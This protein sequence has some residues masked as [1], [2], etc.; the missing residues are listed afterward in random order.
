MPST[1]L[2]GVD[3]SPI[4]TGQQSDVPRDAFLYFNDVYRQCARVGEWKL[5]VTR[6]NTPAYSPDPP[7]G[8]VNLP[9]P[10]PELYNVVSDPQESYDRSERSPDIVADIKAR[11]ARLLPTFPN[12][13]I[14]AWNDTMRHQVENTPADSLPAE[15]QP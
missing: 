8:R 6:Y 12:D 1:Q 13:V 10:N 3:I 2:D 7:H 5:H 15:K 4:L 14:N 9:L 11:I